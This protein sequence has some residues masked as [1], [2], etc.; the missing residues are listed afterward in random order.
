MGERR[1]EEGHD[2]VAHHLVYG[3]LV[4]MDG[5]HHPLQ[6]GIENLA[7]HFGIAAREQF[8]GA[9]E[10]GEEDR[11]LLSLTLKRGLRRE[12]PLGEM[13]G[14]V[15]LRSGEPRLRGRFTAY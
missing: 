14:S 12:D 4:L 9:L 15:G 7:R 10:V 11:D 2:P 13:L 1:P 6:D 3:A 5:F 8:H